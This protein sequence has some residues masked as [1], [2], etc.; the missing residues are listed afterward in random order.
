MPLVWIKRKLVADD[1]ET[2]P[3]A[4][5]LFGSV[6]DHQSRAGTSQEATK[7]AIRRITLGSARS[8]A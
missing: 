6:T 8:G 7:A 4:L 1:D 3:T 5:P 2:K